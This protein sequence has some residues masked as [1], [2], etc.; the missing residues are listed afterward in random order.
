MQMPVSRVRAILKMAQ[1]PVSLQA[2][3]GDGDEASFGD[4]MKLKRS[5][6]AVVGDLS[7]PDE[8]KRTLSGTVSLRGDGLTL[9][10]MEIDRVLSTVFGS[11]FTWGSA[12]LRY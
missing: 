11:G 10:G 3:V 2:P 5:Q 12:L 1:Q 8:M 7:D 9:H 6:G 4:F